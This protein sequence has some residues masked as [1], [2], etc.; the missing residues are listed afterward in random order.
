M[1]A[2]F[3]VVGF[4]AFAV[5]VFLVVA[6]LAL[7]MTLCKLTTR[8]CYN[9]TMTKGVQRKEFARTYLTGRGVFDHSVRQAAS[10][11]T[12]LR[13]IVV[14]TAHLTD[15]TQVF[16][17]HWVATEQPTDPRKTAHLATIASSSPL[18]R[19]LHHATNLQPTRDE[20]PAATG[21]EDVQWSAWHD[22]SRYQLTVVGSIER[23]LHLCE[24]TENEREQIILRARTL[25]RGRHIVFATARATS[26]HATLPTDTL[27]F[28]GLVACTLTLL[29]GTTHAIS[30]IRAHDIR[31]VYITAQPEAMATA[32]AHAAG[33][34]THPK[35]ARHA[36][37]TSFTEHTIYAH[38]TRINTRRI[39]ASLP[40]PLIVAR[41]SLAELAT[42]LDAFR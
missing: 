11:A 23:I 4:F 21:S 36:D 18:M 41:H 34:T 7:Y 13:T 3:F 1:T 27:I 31:L 16:A 33:L 8:L 25:G 19:G 39:L 12:S 10:L 30:R 22:G 37:F 40:Q 35:S 15:G 9:M 32:I 38:A 20:K 26:D 42:L 14:D 28:E 29:P 6:I 24:V 5:D 2:F 17:Q